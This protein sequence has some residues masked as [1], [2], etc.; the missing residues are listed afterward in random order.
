MSP[1]ARIIRSGVGGMAKVVPG[2]RRGDLLGT[3]PGIMSPADTAR[4]R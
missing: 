4:A 3:H 2:E 1:G